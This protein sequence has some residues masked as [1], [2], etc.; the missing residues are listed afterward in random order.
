MIEI[1]VAVFLGAFF[2][3]LAFGLIASWMSAHD[4]DIEDVAI[5]FGLPI[6]G[7][8]IAIFIIIIKTGS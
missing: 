4:L 8:A 6:V 7:A 5:I 1:A 3:L 2:A